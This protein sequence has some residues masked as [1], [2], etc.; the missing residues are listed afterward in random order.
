[1]KK[2]LLKWLIIWAVIFTASINF[3]SS[4]VSFS[5]ATPQVYTAGTAITPLYPTVTSGW[6]GTGA[7]FANIQYTDCVYYSSS[8][9]YLYTTSTNQNNGYIYNSSTGALVY[10]QTGL[11]Y[12]YPE[13]IVTDASGNTY[14]ASRS[15]GKV[16][17][18][19]TGGVETTITGTT[20]PIGEAFDA[21]GNLYIT[22]QTTG[23][24]YKVTPGATV[25]TVLFTGL[26]SPWG[27]ALDASGDMFVSEMGT[28]GDIVEIANATTGGTTKTVFASGFNSPRCMAFDVSGNLL[29]A[30]CNN[31]AIK[32]VSPT[33]VVT[34]VISSGLNSPVGMTI[35]ASGNVYV[36]DFN[37]SKLLKYKPLTFTVSPA[38]P[39]GLSINPY[40]GAIYG[41]PTVAISA[42]TYTVTGTNGTNT[43]T[44]TVTITC[45]PSAPVCASTSECGA[46]NVTLTASASPTGGT[47]SW[48]N[49]SSGGTTLQSSTST[50]YTA[51]YLTTAT[52]Y[53]SYTAG[54]ITTART[55][56]TITVNPTVSTPISGSMVSYPFN[57][58]ANDISGNNNNGIPEPSAAAGPTLTTDRYGNANSAY[59]FNGSTQYFTST[60]KYNDLV[61]FTISIWFQT[62]VAGGKLIGYGASQ[63]GS[64]TYFDRHLYLN[65]S[66]QLYFGIYYS[67]AYQTVNT[68]N[69][70]IDG[71]WHHVVVSVGPTYGTR[72]YVDDVL[73]ASNSSYT[74]PEAQNSYWR[75]GYD[76]LVNWP[77]AP[78]NYYYTGKLDD[79][80]IYN[81]E[82]TAAQITSSDNLNLIGTSASV[83]QGNPIT[84][85]AQ[86]ITGATYSWTDGTTTVTGNPAT[87]SSSA[88]SYTLTVTPPSGCT[89]TATVTPSAGSVYTWTAG[90]NS[91]N[92]TAAGNWTFTSTNSSGQA[93]SFNGTENIVIPAGLSYYPVLTADESIYNITIANGASLTLNGHT[94]Y[95]ACHIYNNSGGNV[96]YGSSSTAGGITF[97]GSLS[98]QYYYGSSSGQ[99]NIANLT[100]NNS[101]AG[102]LTITGG[103]LGINNVLTLTKGNLV[104]NNAG[105]GSLTLFSTATNSATVA[106]IPSGYSITGNVNVQRYITSGAGSRGYRLLT[107]PVNISSSVSGTGNLSLSYL[108]ANVPFGSTNYYG[109]FTEGPG[110]GFTTNGWYNPI[111]YLYNESRATNNTTFVAGK[112]VGVYSIS[113]TT[114]TTISG[115]TTTSGVNIPIG[116]SYLFYYVGSDQSTVTSSSR[117][118]DATTLT[119]TGYLNQGTIPVTFWNTNS[120]TIPY[121]VTTGT[122]NYGLNQVGNPYASTISLNTLYTD[123][124]NASTNPIGAAFYELIPGGNYVSY[125]ASNGHTSDTRASQYIVSGQGFLV[126]ATGTSPAEKLTFKEDQKVAYNSSATLLE[127]FPSGPALA[128]ARIVNNIP[129]KG[130]V[131]SN[132]IIAPVVTKASGDS[133]G[134]HLQL[135]LDSAN[136]AQTGIY[137]SAKES[138]KYDASADAK[139]VDGGTPKVYISSYSTDS[140]QLSINSLSDYAHGKRIRIY[141]NVNTNGTYTISLATIAQMDTT[142]YNIYLVDNLLKDSVDL[143]RYKSYSTNINPAD[144][145]SVGSNR[146]VL[147]I[148]HKP[149]PQYKLATFTGEK[150][151]TG[152]Q[153][154]W[155]AVNA[156]N[157]TGYTLQKLNANGGYDSL[158]AVQSDTSIS[159]YSFVD[160]HPIIGNNTYRLAQNGITGAIT[161][162]A[163]VT[164]GYNSSTPDGALTLYPNPATSIINVNL[165]STTINSPAYVVK[166]YNAMGTL[167]K[168]ENISSTSWKDNV[169]SYKQGIYVMLVKDTNGNIIA[170]AKFSKVE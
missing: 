80:A 105:S 164:I 135:T 28:N 30:D 22:D 27:I 146:F 5:Y 47:F 65:N 1:M 136:Y 61:S 62:T 121:D 102:T 83:C 21:S 144:A 55:P 49:A 155:T 36:A 143:V 116:N 63:T 152:V 69:T 44:A 112:N 74:T 167:V 147:A 99:A 23:D 163:P 38:L 64:S 93:P 46:G 106:A 123:N 110:T 33:G 13:G 158:Y 77:S 56:V 37:A 117:I 50:T 10:T 131:K 90:A 114:V 97:N 39:A 141:E 107:S 73:Q 162:S 79:I 168:N 29:V 59:S 88:T 169:S 139:Q 43:G 52:V 170:Q 140:V 12:S 53:V 150:V 133:T 98:A 124:Y 89:S 9:G 45:N 4:Q 149:V 113:G 127:S 165:T 111:I 19:T 96:L 159:K 157:Y 16:F 48:Y 126:Q 41:T 161:Y 85:T 17:K 160:T 14:V 57:G 120:T 20:N 51:D 71:N 132:A 103:A 2:N 142:D 54:G 26:N 34:T 128:D 137:F 76:N 92:P 7:N 66:G 6:Y 154:N 122:T 119:A 151:T 68:T 75:V 166:I 42:T 108:N 148:A 35:D 129:S 32:R 40:T 24:V 125:N 104:V 15:N 153:L 78:T 8:T 130:N 11:G 84:L 25:A 95:A 70:Y 115:T 58:N 82:L 138:D 87:F 101:V 60:T 81:T 18:Y 145:N 94:L 156:G 3:A 86:T 31:S 72:L 118:P 91:T 134:L 67:G 109:A 100:L